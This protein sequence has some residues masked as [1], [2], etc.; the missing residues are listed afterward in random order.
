MM[1]IRLEF[2]PTGTRHRNHLGH[3]R[4]ESIRTHNFWQMTEGVDGNMISAAPSMEISA[5]PSME[6]SITRARLVGHCA[7]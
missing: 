6:I 4:E 2:P 7:G 1:I 5:A 3:L